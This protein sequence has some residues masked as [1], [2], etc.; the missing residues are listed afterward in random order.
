M[1]RDSPQG[2]LHLAVQRLPNTHGAGEQRR[3]E[4]FN[5]SNDP[6]ESDNQATKMPERTQQLLAI[7][8]RVSAADRD[9]VVK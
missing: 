2:Q 4:L 5:I 1:L 9:S 7:L 3:I 6:T 8:Q